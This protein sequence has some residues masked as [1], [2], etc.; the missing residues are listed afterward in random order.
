MRDPQRWRE[1]SEA[2]SS[3]VRELLARAEKPPA[4]TP[5]QRARSSA[6]VARLAA[7]PVVV[8]AFGWF[9]GIAAAAAIGAG[10]A[11]VL[12]AGIE[13]VE[14]RR[15][16]PA[17]APP[18]T[19]AMMATRPA[20]RA[21]PARSPPPSRATAPKPD[22][23]ASATAAPAA[24][25]PSPG[26]VPELPPPE[27]EETAV[28]PPAPP[29]PTSAV[30]APEGDS[31]VR[32]TALLEE[33]RV[34]LDRSP[35]EALVRLQ[36][37]AREFPDGK[38]EMEREFLTITALRRLGR[39][40]EARTRGEALLWRSKGSPYEERIRRTLGGEP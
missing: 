10:S 26:K 33:A 9:Q 7:I 16:R 29:A 1:G 6:R 5:R 32:E 36:Q 34:R 21:A 30:A 37:H 11:V 3:R 39:R 24:A 19:S 20:G 12:L 27:E 22:V 15:E 23:V 31:L 25:A 8:A 38:L 2:R 35:G 28:P 14:A 4:L 18:P 40:A 13:I 17:P